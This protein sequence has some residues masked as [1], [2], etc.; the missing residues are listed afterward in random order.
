M[1]KNPNHPK[2][3]SIIKVEPIRRPED[4]ERIRVFLKNKPRDLCLFNFGVNSNL[5]AI[6]LVNL[7]VGQVRYLNPGESLVLRERKTKKRR[8]VLINNLFWKSIQNLLASDKMEN[9]KDEEYLFQSRNGKGKL[10]ANTLNAM[11]KQWTSS[12]NLPGNFGSQSLRKTW[13][14]QHY[15]NKGTSL[16]HIMK[17]MNHSSERISLEYLSITPQSEIDILMQEI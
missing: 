5:R 6:D 16:A 1:T 7:K 2:T 3:G 12:I 4:I 8:A 11:V 17:F 9:A 10:R 15:F 13:A 14:V